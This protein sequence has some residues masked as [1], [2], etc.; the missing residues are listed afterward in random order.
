VSLI[1]AALLVV[2]VTP[3]FI[4]QRCALLGIATLIPV[5]IAA[6]QIAYRVSLPP[7]ALLILE[8]VVLLVAGEFGRAHQR[9]PVST[10]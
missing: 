3:R 8:A 1:I 7:T 6:V 4:V 2:A 10:A 5:S 9:R